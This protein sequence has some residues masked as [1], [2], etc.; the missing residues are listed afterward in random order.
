MPRISRHRD[1]NPC[2]TVDSVIG[3]MVVKVKSSL[4]GIC[5]WVGAESASAFGAAPLHAFTYSLQSPPAAV[6]GRL[7]DGPGDDCLALI[8]RDSSSDPGPG[9]KPGLRS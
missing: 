7:T 9:P 8:L 6:I 1:W 5:G 2:Q 3:S 4:I